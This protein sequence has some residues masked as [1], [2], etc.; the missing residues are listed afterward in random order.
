MIKKPKAT[1]TTKTLYFKTW[2]NSKIL[3]DW[4]W[5]FFL[6]QI[7]YRLMLRINPLR[8]RKTKCGKQHKKVH[9]LQRKRSF[10]LLPAKTSLIF[11]SNDCLDM[12]LLKNVILCSKYFMKRKI[13]V[14]TISGTLWT[15]IQV[16]STVDIL[17]Y[18]YTNIISLLVSQTFSGLSDASKEPISV[19]NCMK[20]SMV[21]IFFTELA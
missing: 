16:I 9:I 12:Q 1:K 7:N 10:L 21:L 6:F 3:K 15:N 20:K 18:I 13:T 17:F 14:L 2:N 8:Y 11:L 5:Y 4:G 19:V